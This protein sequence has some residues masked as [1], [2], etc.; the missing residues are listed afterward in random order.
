MH[1]T[2]EPVNRQVR[3]AARPVGLPEATD[4]SH[5]EEPVAQP[6][7][8]EVLV[9]VLFV[10]LDPAMRGWMSEGRSY[11]RP[12]AIGE[13]MRALGA[14]RVIASNHRG[15]VVGDHVTGLFGVQ[16]FALASGDAV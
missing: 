12:V 14:G 1:S 9:K 8:G 2:V 16:E 15:V 4:W 11:I 3:L 13:V 5:T 6:G 7:E 10:S